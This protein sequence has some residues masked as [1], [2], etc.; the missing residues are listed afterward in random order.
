MFACR[1]LFSKL[2]VQTLRIIICLAY[3]SNLPRDHHYEVHDVPHV[4]EVAAPVQD[5]TQGQD[6][7]GG[8]HCKYTKEVHFC[9]FL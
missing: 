8:L 9:R 6:L 3:L 1:S 2:L 4:P 7:Q 5:Q